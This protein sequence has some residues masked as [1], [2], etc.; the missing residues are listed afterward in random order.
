MKILCKHFACPQHF[1]EWMN[2][3]RRA[4]RNKLQNAHCVDFSNVKQLFSSS[5]L[6]SDPP[7]TSIVADSLSNRLVAKSL[8][9]VMLKIRPGVAHEP[10]Q[11]SQK[12]KALTNP[13]PYQSVSIIRNA[14]PKLNHCSIAKK[15]TNID[16][17]TASGHY[18]FCYM[19][20]N[21]TEG[22]QQELVMNER[23]FSISL[24]SLIVFDS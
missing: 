16:T 11:K 22:K 17:D 19:R 23:G 4:K 7:S 8:F 5:A 10:M 3:L 20:R 13:S 21:K 14:L 1:L 2:E 24:D 9:I 15:I 6:S 18:R 12:A